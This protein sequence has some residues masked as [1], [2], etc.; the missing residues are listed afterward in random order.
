MKAAKPQAVL[1]DI[2]GTLALKGD[3]S[4]YEWSK[5]GMDTPNQPVVELVRLIHQA[6]IQIILFSGRE[7]SCRD[8]T[9]QW[10]A[11]HAI[12]YDQLYMRASRDNRKDAIV[13]LELFEKYIREQYQIQFVL[14]DRNQVV[15]M[16]RSLGLACFQVAEGDF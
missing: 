4:P 9:K 16:W 5:V 15:A 14:D 8:L 11:T 1:C 2:D 7:D 10:L 13:K 3:R 12:P 6:K